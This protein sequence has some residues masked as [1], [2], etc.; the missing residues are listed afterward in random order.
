MLTLFLNNR[1]VVTLYRIFDTPSPSRHGPKTTQE[2]FVLS[3]R[4]TPSETSVKIVDFY[5]LRVLPQFLNS[6]HRSLSGN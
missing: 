1:G 5:K 4:Q 2:Y 6:F 3:Q